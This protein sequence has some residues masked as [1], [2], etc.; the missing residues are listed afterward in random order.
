[1]KML[2]VKTV[3]GKTVLD[4]EI[5][6]PIVE[7]LVSQTVFLNNRDNPKDPWIIEELI[8]EKAGG[9]ETPKLGDTT[10]SMVGKNN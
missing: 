6:D 3:T 9:N 5:F 1:M 4:Y 8:D 2:R 10:I 7:T